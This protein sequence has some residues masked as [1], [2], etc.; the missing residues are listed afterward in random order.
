[1][2]YIF[3]FWHH[4]WHRTSWDQPGPGVLSGSVEFNYVKC[5]SINSWEYPCIFVFPGD[6]Y[7]VWPFLNL[8]WQCRSSEAPVSFQLKWI[9]WEHIGK[10][11]WSIAG[12]EAKLSLPRG[13]RPHLWRFTENRFA[14]DDNCSTWQRSADAPGGKVGK[15]VL[16]SH[17]G[18]RFDHEDNVDNNEVVRSLDHLVLKPKYSSFW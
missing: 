4:T 12:V 15:S 11:C 3:L 9:H 16:C 6:G 18:E 2:P 1:M 17:S 7:L 13:S 8:S 14:T 10:A 5:L